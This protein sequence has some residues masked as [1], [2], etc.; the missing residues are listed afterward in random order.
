MILNLITI[1][2]TAML[3]ENFVLVK[4]MGICPF[5][6]VSKKIS[7]APF[8]FPSVEKHPPEILPGGLSTG[9]FGNICF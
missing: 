8:S 2:F 5:L 7:T 3:A 4:F 1:A 9:F 6:G